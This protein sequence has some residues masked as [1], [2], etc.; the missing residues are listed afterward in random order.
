MIIQSTCP[1]LKQLASARTRQSET[2]DK[3][4]EEEHVFV[5]TFIRTNATQLKI[6]RNT[7]GG[8]ESNILVLFVYTSL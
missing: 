3:V 6:R 8:E 1:R 2:K 4:E 5:H 7:A